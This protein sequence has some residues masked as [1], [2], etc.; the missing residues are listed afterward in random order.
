M[1]AL[2]ADAAAVLLPLGSDEAWD[3]R[4]L[5]WLNQ[6]RAQVRSGV[7]A[8]AAITDVRTL[9]DEMRLI[10]DAHELATMRDAARISTAAHA[11]RDAGD[12]AGAHGIS[13]S[14]PSCC[15]NSAATARS[16]RLH[17]DRR[18]RRQ[19]LRAALRAE[20]RG[21]EGRRPAADRRRLRARRLRVRHHAHLSRS[22]ADSAPRSATCTSW[23][24]PRRRRRWRV[25]P[26]NA[27]NDAARR[28]GE[29]AGAG[30]ASTS[31]CSSGQRR[32][33]A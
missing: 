18:R 27:W 19:C 31:A 20:R 12:G 17:V 22:T 1:P 9:L 26:G 24:S 29:G 5:G 32:T 30:H 14:K 4:V 7:A 13:K 33:R 6:V 23:C 11:T 10:K 15:T 3:A 2:L 8:P 25:A 28:R 16:S 21:A